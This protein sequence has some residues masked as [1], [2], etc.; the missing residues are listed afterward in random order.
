[1]FLMKFVSY[2]AQQTYMREISS[3]KY[4]ADDTFWDIKHVLSVKLY[5]SVILEVCCFVEKD[6]SSSGAGY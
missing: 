1:M 6:T 3:Y 2:K 5:S 4:T